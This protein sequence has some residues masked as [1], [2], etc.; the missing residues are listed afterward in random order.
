[1]SMTTKEALHQ[2][3]DELPDQEGA[4]AEQVLAALRDRTADLL[5]LQLLAA[6]YDD[7]DDTDEERAGAAEARAQIARR[8]R[9]S[10]EE[11]RREIGW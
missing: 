2:L 4:A 9:V 5:R 7:E 8:E 3:V 10:N 6:S 11:L 1:M